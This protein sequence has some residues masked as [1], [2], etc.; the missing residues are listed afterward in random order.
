MN[1]A[2]RC[3]PYSDSAYHIQ[4][5]NEII[6][7]NTQQDI[8]ENPSHKNIVSYAGVFWSIYD[9]STPKPQPS[10]VF[11]GLRWALFLGDSILKIC[12]SKIKNIFWK[13][14]LKNSDPCPEKNI[15]SGEFDQIIQDGILR[16][17]LNK[18]SSQDPFNIKPWIH[19]RLSYL[20]MTLS[21]H[22]EYSLEILKS[23]IFEKGQSYDRLVYFFGKGIFTS[24]IES[25]WKEQKQVA[26]KLFYHSHLKKMAH[27]MYQG[28][29]DEVRRASKEAKGKP[30]DL[31][32]LL[33]RMGL[34]AFCDSVLQVDVRDIADELAP[35]INKVLGYI[36][37]ALEP[38]LIPIGENYHAFIKERNTVHQWM[39]IVIKRVVEKHRDKTTHDNLFIDKILEM[40]EQGREEELIEL[41]ISMVLGGHETT[42]RLMLGAFYGLMRHPE[43]IHEIR[44]EVEKF[45]L[46]NPNNEEWHSDYDSGKGLSRLHT[47]V[48][49]AIRLFPPVW[50]VSRSPKQDIEIHGEKLQKGTQVLISLLILN[51]LHSRWGED[52]EVFR[53]TRFDEISAHDRRKYFFPFVDGFSRCPGDNFARM[54]SVLA[55]AG[56]LKEF[57]ITLANPEQRPEPSS[58]GTFRLFEILPVIISPR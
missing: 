45:I 32:L 15:L 31:V 6:P 56:L 17:I 12:P 14:L 55:I 40:D 27:C 7:P 16:F 37:G 58:S 23:D 18:L 26:I 2:P 51:R 52:A 43:Y 47:V 35:A 39:K 21:L 30:V 24:R 25:R 28:L 10:Q 20:P 46:E 53:P 11:W 44:D 4:H 13:S 50:L 5:N 48:Y 49:E 1:I 54:E 19:F 38:I 36:N 57:D 29:I 22:P 9:P 42:A 34:F 33:S 41:M 3:S 8:E